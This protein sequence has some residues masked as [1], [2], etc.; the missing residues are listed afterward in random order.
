M[1]MEF[2]SVTVT[3]CTGKVGWL[4]YRGTASNCC[5]RCSLRCFRSG[6]SNIPSFFRH[7]YSSFE[8]KSV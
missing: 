1:F 4:W 7:S 3:V 2:V 5:S 6:S 8:I